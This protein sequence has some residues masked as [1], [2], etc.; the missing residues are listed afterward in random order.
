[1]TSL[2]LLL[3]I[4]SKSIDGL[5]TKQL[6]R[7]A[8]THPLCRVLLYKHKNKMR[9]KYVLEHLNEFWRECNMRK[10]DRRWTSFHYDGSEYRITYRPQGIYSYLYIAKVVTETNEYPDSETLFCLF[11]QLSTINWRMSDRF[12]L[13]KF[14]AQDDKTRQLIIQDMYYKYG[15]FYVLNSTT[16]SEK[17]ITNCDTIADC[18]MIKGGFTK[19]RTIIG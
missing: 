13:Y 10:D 6:D 7:I 16:T 12:I 14:S 9:H 17:A 3:I 2:S 8:K 4:L 5:S 11:H 15:R 1:M 19:F 18:C